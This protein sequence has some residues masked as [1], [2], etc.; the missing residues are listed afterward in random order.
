MASEAGP[1]SLMKHAQWDKSPPG[2]SHCTRLRH[3]GH[4]ATAPMKPQAGLSCLLWL[5]LHLPIILLI[6]GITCPNSFI[7]LKGPLLV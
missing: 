5:A 6:M 3:F 1:L 7:Q 4:V 2:L